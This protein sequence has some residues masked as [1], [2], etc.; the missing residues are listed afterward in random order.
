MTNIHR[1]QDS[2]H[3]E[4]SCLLTTYCTNQIFDIFPKNKKKLKIRWASASRMQNSKSAFADAE[5][6]DLPKNKFLIFFR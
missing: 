4:G 5:N 1:H 2:Q 3:S 6:L